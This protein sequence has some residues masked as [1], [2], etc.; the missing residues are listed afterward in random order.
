V[1]RIHA[2]AV[3]IRGKG[4]LLRGR[5]G[6]GKSDLALRLIDGGAKLIADDVVEVEKSGARIEAQAP[7]RLR[8]KMEVRGVGVL[9]V[10]SV[11]RARIV[12]VVDLVGPDTVERYPEPV[13]ARILG[14]RIKLLKLWAFEAS[15]PAKLRLAVR[16]READ[17]TA[18]R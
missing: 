9:A 5:S 8:G 2:T 12:L 3:A 17:S 4:V 15:A 7:A 11:A 10:P 14:I 6:A 16:G 1:K 13:F 18:P